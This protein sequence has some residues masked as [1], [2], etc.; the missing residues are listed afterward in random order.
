MRRKKFLR[1]LRDKLWPAVMLLCLLGAGLVL[2][3]ILI[4]IT[5]RGLQALSWEMITTPPQRAFYLGGS[6]GILNAIMGSLYLAVGATIIASLVAIPVVLYMHTYGKGK[7]Q[8]RL[9]R[10]I[11]D[12]MWG[13]PSIVYGAFVF[14]FMLA[15]GM[16]AS[17]LAG[18]LTLALVSLPIL[19]RTF[20]EVALMVPKALSESTLALGT[21]RVELAGILL[22]QTVPGLLAGMF[23]AFV[24]GI[25]D[26]ASILF[27]AGYTDSMPTSLLR[28][29][30]SLPLAI[31][32]QLSTPFPEVQARAYT[33]ALVL[34]AIILLFGILSYIVRAR[35]G[36]YIIR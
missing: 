4:V 25:G 17:L 14:T 18:I 8:T 2:S 22:R 7:R 13:M 15:V 31:Y 6:G 33:A 10:L 12:V 21:T 28:P 27:T 35:L 23:L 11:L 3:S 32:F 34:T 5:S 20:D 30:A 36:R 1:V 26:G 19:T 9:I 29:V 16:R 24:R